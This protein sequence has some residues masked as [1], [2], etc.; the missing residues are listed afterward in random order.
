MKHYAKHGDPDAEFDQN[1]AAFAATLAIEVRDA[2]RKERDERLR[3]AIENL[4]RDTPVSRPDEDDFVYGF[5]KGLDTVLALLG[6]KDGG[7]VKDGK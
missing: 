1:I 4:E 3:L 7:K 2:D 5:N 6:K